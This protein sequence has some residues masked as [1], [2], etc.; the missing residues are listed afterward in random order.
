EIIECSSIQEVFT[1]L[2]E[3]NDIDL[4]LLD[5]FFGNNSI[6][7]QLDSMKTSNYLPPVLIV[8][9]CDELI[10]GIR[11]VKA[12][13]KGYINKMASE[14]DI[15]EAISTV[16]LGGFYLSQELL[17]K[18]IS[19]SSS[20]GKVIDNPFDELSEREFQIAMFMIRGLDTS[21]ISINLNLSMSAVSTY[22]NRVF[23][24]LKVTKEIEVRKLANL[25]GIDFDTHF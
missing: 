3:H 15:K 21:E 8:S 12:G 5:V 1:A 10:Y 23:T 14:K 2:K 24:K 6:I 13:A 16:A 11:A 22:K 17:S 20:T 25:Y 19:I 18:Y 7:Q 9:M 4:M